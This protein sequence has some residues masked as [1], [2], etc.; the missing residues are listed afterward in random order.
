MSDGSLHLK[1]DRVLAVLEDQGK[2][3]DEFEEV[4]RILTQGLRGL[5]PLFAQQ[6][7]M[8][9]L[10]LNAATEEPAGDGEL[11]GLIASIATSLNEQ[12]ENL[13]EIVRVLQ[14][15]PDVVESAASDGIRLAM[16]EAEPDEPHSNGHAV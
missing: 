3:Q 11:S 9:V 8:L 16:A 1:L 13:N 10:I 14:S 7:E 6:R 12:T 4:L 15:L 2:R 5:T